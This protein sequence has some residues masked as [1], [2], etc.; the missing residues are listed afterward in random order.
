M[1]FTANCTI[2]RLNSRSVKLDQIKIGINCFG[3][4]KLEF[5]PV[6]F[7]FGDSI[8]IIHFDCA[9]CLC[10]VIPVCFRKGNCQFPAGR[11]A[12]AGADIIVV[13]V[14]SCGLMHQLTTNELD[15]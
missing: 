12:V 14:D 15:S 10:A 6:A 1:L 3:I 9:V 4:G 11:R 8:G 5:G 7:V 13:A 2:S